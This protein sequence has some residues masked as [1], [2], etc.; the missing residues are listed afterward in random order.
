MQAFGIVL[1]GLLGLVAAPIF[2]Y[3]VVKF[4][5]PFR[6][7]TRMAWWCSLLGI[8]LLLAELAVVAALGIAGSQ[9]SLGFLFLPLNGLLAAA[10]APAVAGLL[11]T[12]RRNLVRWWPAVAALAWVVGVV[13]ISWQQDVIETLSLN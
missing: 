9:R 1:C 2:C 11:L 3:G 8:L 6:R 4:V 12:G 7:L 5:R 13:A 10:A